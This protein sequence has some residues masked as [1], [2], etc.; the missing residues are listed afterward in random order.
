M[1]RIG[2]LITQFWVFEKAA[3]LIFLGIYIIFSAV[4]VKQARLMAETLDVELDNVIVFVSYIH[5]V[6][7]VGVFIV[8][9]VLL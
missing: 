9:A 4:V 5:L 7:A 8:S 1:E 2:E 6:L 3:V